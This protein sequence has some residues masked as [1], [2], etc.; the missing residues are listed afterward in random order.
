MTRRVD[1]KLTNLCRTRGCPPPKK[2]TFPSKYVYIRTVTRYLLVSTTSFLYTAITILLSV[3]GNRIIQYGRALHI[4]IY[5]CAT[6]VI[7]VG[8]HNIR[9][10]SGELISLRL[11]TE[12]QTTRRIKRFVLSLRTIVRHNAESYTFWILH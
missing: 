4:I 5:Q 11:C 2:N 10:W 3:T 7:V 12:I 1:S 6:V 8:V 9:F